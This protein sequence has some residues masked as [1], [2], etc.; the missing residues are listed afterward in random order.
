MDSIYK[1][2][3]KLKERLIIKFKSMLNTFSTLIKSST[4]RD[5]LTL[6]LGTII[7]SLLNF[8]V[9]IL[10]S[11]NLELQDFGLFITGLVFIQLICDL[12]EMGLNPSSFNFIS[13]TQQV[14]RLR[15]LKV[16]FILR[17]STS[18]LVSFVVLLFAGAISNIFF[19]NP[20]ITP[21]IQLSSV[22]VFAM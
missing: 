10:L 2:K 5:T 4:S 9:L 21:Y 20:N 19:Q 8:L 18:T 14:D 11:Q 7:Y 15:N 16:L 1:L 3:G 22:G 6:M 13:P 12:F 17:L